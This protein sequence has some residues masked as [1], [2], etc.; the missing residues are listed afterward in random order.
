MQNKYLVALGAVVLLMA[1]VV[2]YYFNLLPTSTQTPK[3]ET[4]NIGGIDIQ[5]PKGAKIEM[6]GNTP[7]LER[8]VSFA[9]DI[10]RDARKNIMLKIK[11]AKAILAKDQTNYNAWMDLAIHYK[12]A[13][14]FKGA[15]EVWLFLNDAA[16]EQSLSMHN[17]GVLYHLSLR[18]FPKA[19]T[20]TRGAITRD[21]KEVINYLSLH[22]LYR[23][24]YKKETT[25][26]ADILKEGLK[27]IPNHPDLL[28]SLGTYYRDDVKD[29]RRAI[30]YYLKARD[31]IEKNGNI[32]LAR[33]IDQDIARM[34]SVR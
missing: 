25:S 22:E 30:E 5:V 1:G 11:E 13:G 29:T 14:D 8:E 27:A 7:S 9:V 24:S 15:E 12:V 10:P 21:P 16:K 20:M 6:V 26:A 33:Q 4:V 23:Y 2:L 3:N 19:E 17:L 18:D 28:L 34:K 31:V 32:D